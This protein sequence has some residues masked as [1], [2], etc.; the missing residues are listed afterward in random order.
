MD[1][2]FQ[3]LVAIPSISGDEA[4][5]QQFVASELSKHSEN[6][7]QDVLN[8]LTVQ[9]GNGPQK[10][11]LTA[12][13][14]EVGFIVTYISDEGYIYFQ[15]V[16]GI[17]ADIAVGQVVRILTR[18]GEVKGIVG[19]AE[20]WDT[21]S[22]EYSEN[23]TPYKELWIDIG[24]NEHAQEVISVGDQII[25]DTGYYKLG[26]NYALARGADNKLGVYC[27]IKLV[28][29]FAQ[30]TNPEASLFAVTMAQEEIG[31]RGAQ[32]VVNRVQPQYSL[33]IDTIGATDT[34][35]TDKEEIGEIT[36]GAGPT[37]SRGSNTNADLF[38]VLEEIAKRENIPYQVEAEAGPTA[39][40]ADAI[41]ISGLG[42]ATAVISI[43]ARYT[44]FPGEV[45]CWDD[46]QNCIKLVGAFLRTV[47]QT[48]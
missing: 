26:G 25:Y 30:Q 7:F 35:I 16:G 4:L 29:Q 8:S 1:E 46:V 6:R 21:A 28:E 5:F 17:D 33:I 27:V 20:V 15:P 32:A 13:A 19:R 47:R 22:A 48:M 38:F 39:T 14:D 12:H 36:L 42:S 31:S 41:Q 44:H 3:K 18:A 10:V 45:F 11:L 2:L 24:D 23:I 40:D 37:I 34:P 9:V 43:P